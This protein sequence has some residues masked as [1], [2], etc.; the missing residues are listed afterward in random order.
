MTGFWAG[1]MQ[2]EWGRKAEAQREIVAILHKCQHTKSLDAM[3]DSLVISLPAVC[4]L[5][6]FHSATS[7]DGNG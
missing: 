1:E 3:I 4:H 2:S 6:S 7:V 5:E